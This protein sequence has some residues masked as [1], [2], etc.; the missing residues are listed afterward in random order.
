MSIRGGRTPVGNRLTS[1]GRRIFTIASRTLDS[2]TS[3]RSS[4]RSITCFAGLAARGTN[5]TLS[6][7]AGSE[8]G[9]DRGHTEIVIR[10]A[11][12]SAGPS[13]IAL[14]RSRRAEVVAFH[15]GRSADLIERP[16][17]GAARRKESAGDRGTV[18]NNQVANG[19]RTP[20]TSNLGSGRDAT[21]KGANGSSV[22]SITDGV[23]LSIDR[24]GLETLT[25]SNV[26]HGTEF[27]N[28]TALSSRLEALV[29]SAGNAVGVELVTKVAIQGGA[30]TG[31]RGRVASHR[32][33]TNSNQGITPVGHRSTLRS[34]APLLI[35]TTSGRGKR[36]VT[37]L[38]SN[39]ARGTKGSV[40]T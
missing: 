29:S 40:R 12:R 18:V 9:I 7:F 10:D 21:S 17:I 33:A 24:R 31:H 37:G 13:T 20:D 23:V 14:A 25:M 35:G 26:K 5:N 3:A 19:H 28:E 16:I 32:H 11:S 30:L 4:R 8:D 15:T 1:N 6:A 34:R 2:N 22:T 38:A 36:F 27:G 39:L